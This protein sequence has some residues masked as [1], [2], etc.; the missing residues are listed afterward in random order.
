MPRSRTYAACIVAARALFCA[1]AAG[2]AFYKGTS[3]DERKSIF[4]SGHRQLTAPAN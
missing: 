4:S 1:C 2:C 3:F